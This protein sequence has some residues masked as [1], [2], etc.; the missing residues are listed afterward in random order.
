MNILQFFDKESDTPKTR[1]FS[2]ISISGLANGLLLI[3]VNVAAENILNHN[4]EERLF[5]L[6]IITFVLFVYAQQDALYSTTLA[7]EKAIR[8]VRLRIVDKIRHSDLLFIENMERGNIYTKLTQDTNTISQYAITIINLGQSAIV[9]VFSF[10]YLAWLSP[11]S[12]FLITIFMSVVLWMYFSHLKIFSKE[13]QKVSQKEAEFFDSLNH[14]LDGFKEIK[15]NYRKNEDVFSHIDTIS[16]DTTQF[17]INFGVKVVRHTM[18][19]QVA[20][21]F[22][23]TILIFIMPLFTQVYG[24]II[25]KLT[26]IVFFII[27]PINQFV[28]GISMIART[29]VAVKNLDQLEQQIDKIASSLTMPSATSELQF[30]ELKLERMTLD[31]TDKNGK[32]LFSVGPIDMTIKPGE[33]LFIVGG[34]G[35]GKSTLLKLLSG[36]YYPV[37][38]CIYLDNEEVDYTNYQEY[39]ELF[40]I[41]FTDFYLFDKLYGLPP[42]EE[43]RVKNLLQIM[44]LENK[45][46]YT[47]EG[48]FTTVNLSTGQRKRLA[49]VVALLEDKPIYLFDEWAAD[50]DPHF[51]KYFYEVILRNLKQRGKTIIAVTHDDKYFET[52]DR[53]LKMEYGQ[54]VSERSTD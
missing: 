34:N 53:I 47:D 54:L 7:V 31:Y 6:Y 36:L 4:L 23:L 21:Y 51:K 43:K 52:A 2:M 17:K 44:E 49:L 20:F 10:L 13:L 45:T 15:V 24:N 1:I 26:T 3:L 40:S 30:K 14:V 37:S 42:I 50:Q 38:G 35:S 16:N 12:F 11:L 27:G 46:K 8:K 22:F 29:N 25:F 5:F 19:F 28:T 33:I 39:R 32:P 9:L 48:K 18:Y 41:I